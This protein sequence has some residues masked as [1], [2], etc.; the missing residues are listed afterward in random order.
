MYIG[1]VIG[2]EQLGDPLALRLE[3]GVNLGPQKGLRE[4][5]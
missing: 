4:V 2:G 3:P 1:G 5:H